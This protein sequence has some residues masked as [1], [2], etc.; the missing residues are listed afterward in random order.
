MKRAEFFLKLAVLLLSMTRKRRDYPLAINAAG[1][2]DV[3]VG[4]IRETTRSK[5]V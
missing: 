4:R 1:Q 2:D 5:T 3:Y